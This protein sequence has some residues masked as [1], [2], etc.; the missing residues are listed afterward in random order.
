MGAKSCTSWWFIPLFIGLQQ[1]K[2]VQDYV[3]PY[4]FI[5]WPF[6]PQ[7][8]Q[9]TYNH[10][11]HYISASYFIVSSS[12]IGITM[13]F[14]PRACAFWQ[15]VMCGM[16]PRQGRWI[17]CFGEPLSVNQVDEW[18][19]IAILN[20]PEKRP[21]VETYE[22]TI[23][24]IKHRFWKPYDYYWMRLPYEITIF[25]EGL[26]W[27]H[28]NKQVNLGW[29]ETQLILTSFFGTLSSTSPAKKIV[30]IVWKW[31]KTSDLKNMFCWGIAM[32]N[33]HPYPCVMC[34][35]VYQPINGG[36]S[37]IIPPIHKVDN[38]L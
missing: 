13:V 9:H 38:V 7:H 34:I 27:K 32:N 21:C 29:V 18:I 31:V 24:M 37:A 10:F 3:Y 20:H 17:K 23:W 36:C 11:N 5:I 33:N 12:W 19:L 8:C 28:V 30:S 26:Q 2:V 25:G 16:G 1:S 6:N 14:A 15:Q 4:I 35:D 22:S